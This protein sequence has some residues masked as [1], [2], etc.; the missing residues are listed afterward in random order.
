MTRERVSGSNPLVYLNANQVSSGWVGDYKL[1]RDYVLACRFLHCGILDRTGTMGSGFPWRTIDPIPAVTAEMPSFA[2]LCDRR[3]EEIVAEAMAFDREIRV[4]WSGGIDSTTALIAV[5][6]AA[7]RQR[8][9]RRVRV[10]L[11]MQSVL[12]HPRFYRE[13]IDGDLLVHAVQ[14]PMSRE[15]DPGAL[16]VTGEHGDQLFGSQLLAPYVRRGVA[17]RAYQDLLPL[18]LLERL[19]HPLAA[20]HAGRFLQ[21]VIDAAPVPI[22]SLFDCLWWLNFCAKWQDVSLRMVAGTALETRTHFDSLRHFFR[23]DPFQ[24]WAMTHTPG[25]PV[26]DWRAYKLAAK[27]YIHAFSG[28]THYFRLKIKEDSLRH[29]LRGRSASERQ[30]VFMRADFCPVVSWFRPPEPGRLRRWLRPETPPGEPAWPE[31]VGS[32]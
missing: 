24:V 12:E 19:H 32:G 31:F 16:N 10:L 1:G 18:V 20:A 26:E 4:F 5:M 29:V 15:L 17:G 30:R 6:T 23:T 14:A 3:G 13:F 9:R 27:D 8:Y 28:D 11:S 25:S 21:P 2:T 22:V 7:E